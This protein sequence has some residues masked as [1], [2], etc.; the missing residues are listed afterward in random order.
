MVSAGLPQNATSVACSRWTVPERPFLL[1]ERVV[2]PASA[3][4]TALPVCANTSSRL[5]L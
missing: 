3:M 4:R 5:L 1:A 2:S